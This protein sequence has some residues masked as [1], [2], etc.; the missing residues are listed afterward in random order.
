MSQLL[1]AIPDD[2]AIR[3]RSTPSAD[4]FAPFSSMDVDKP[5]KRTSISV[6]AGLFSGWRDG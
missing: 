5:S 3:M 6:C 2:K 1:V 4:S